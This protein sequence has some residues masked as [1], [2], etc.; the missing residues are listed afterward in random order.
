MICEGDVLLVSPTLPP[1]PGSFVLIWLQPGDG[2]TYVYAKRLLLPFP[3][4]KQDGTGPLVAVE[5]FQ[6]ARRFGLDMKQ[7]RAV[8]SIV[9][10]SRGGTEPMREVPACYERGRLQ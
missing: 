7:V 5:M 2:G 8:H 3:H 9:G 4:F 1:V 10:L 6:P